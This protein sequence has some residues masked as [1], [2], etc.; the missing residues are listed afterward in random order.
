LNPF[1]SHLPLSF[2]SSFSSYSNSSFF[3]LS[4]I[5]YL[6]QRSSLICLNAPSLPLLSLRRSSS[7]TYLIC[8][9][10]P[11]AFTYSSPSCSLISLS[12][13]A[14]LPYFIVYSHT[15]SYKLVPILT[16]RFFSSLWHNLHVLP[17]LPL[18]PLS[19][20]FALHFFGD[21]VVIANADS[22]RSSDHTLLRVHLLHKSHNVS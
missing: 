16:H 15:I 11:S 18:L 4:S 22:A 1:L 13:I 9:M 14:Y 17:V 3:P 12:A 2:C 20:T 7:P 5:T 8:P 10:L 21:T 6:P 19:H